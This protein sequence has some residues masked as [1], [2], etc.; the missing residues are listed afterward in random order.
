MIKGGTLIGTARCKEFRTREG[1]LSAAHNLVKKGIDSLIIIGGDG[2][3][4]GA[5]I[6]RSEWTG[7]LE[8]LVSEGKD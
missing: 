8:E 3:L 4:T 5:N 7:L 1:R 2:S 6:L